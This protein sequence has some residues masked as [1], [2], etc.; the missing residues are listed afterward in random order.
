VAKQPN[1]AHA[2]KSSRRW[3]KAKGSNGK[4]ANGEGWRVFETEGG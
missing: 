3:V 1:A 2:S 4:R